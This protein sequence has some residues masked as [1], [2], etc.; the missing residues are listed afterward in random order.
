MAATGAAAVL[1]AEAVSAVAVAGRAA[2]EQADHGDD[3]EKTSPDC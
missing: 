1:A 2:E 3:A